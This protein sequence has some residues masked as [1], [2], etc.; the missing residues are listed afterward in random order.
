MFDSRGYYD[1]GVRE[2]LTGEESLLVLFHRD[3]WAGAGPSR[4]PGDSSA[5]GWQDYWVEDVK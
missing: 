5:D 3:G 4:R 2:E 1:G